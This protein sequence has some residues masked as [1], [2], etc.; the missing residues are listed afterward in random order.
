MTASAKRWPPSNVTDDPNDT[1]DEKNEI[2]RCH[3]LL[4]DRERVF[5]CYAFRVD[6][7]EEGL[8][9]DPYIGLTVLFPG[10]VHVSEIWVRHLW[11]RVTTLGKKSQWQVKAVEMLYEQNMLYLA[12]CPNLVDY[13]LAKNWL[14]RYGDQKLESISLTFPECYPHRVLPIVR[15]L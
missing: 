15:I 5:S 9:G 3:G 8:R 2:R 10:N 13:T 6:P 14:D 11:G 7:Q 1:Q 4:I 12:P